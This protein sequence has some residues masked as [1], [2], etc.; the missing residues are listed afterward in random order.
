MR[1]LLAGNHLSAH[2]CSRAPIEDLSD[3]LSGR[4]YTCLR[5]SSFLNGAVRGAHLA[6][7]AVLRYAAYDVAVVDLYSGRAFHWG[8]ML[9]RIFRSLGKPFVV[10]L[11]GGDLPSYATARPDAVRRCLARAS[12]VV[13]PS[14]YLIDSM[15]RYRSDIRY[16]PN[17][18]D[19]EQLPYRHRES[20]APRLV[21]V[22]AFHR[23]Y[24]PVLAPRMMRELLKRFPGATL[25]MLGRDKGD[26]SYQETV[27][28][29]RRLNVGDR[30]VFAGPQPHKE[31][32]KF[33]DA[34]DIFVSTTNFDNTPVS[35]LEAMA[36]GSC[37]VST[38]VG[39]VPWLIENR[40]NGLLVP[41]DHPAAMAEAVAAIVEDCGLAAR[42]SSGAR[43]TALRSDWSQVL[44]KWEALFA[45]IA[46]EGATRTDMAI[47][48]RL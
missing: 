41:P 48:G 27:E 44:P 22:R 21:W 13:A 40:S 31:V 14:G 45:E 17:P 8:D 29:A 47:A 43:A 23:I 7:T 25:T 20:A 46:G 26:G 4:G 39:G 32:G 1:V 30:I 24:N 6:G 15:R 37:V 3:R 18:V 19:I 35:V 33:L 38:A 2:G 11:H 12:A 34:A 9:S 10:A 42:L 5:V 36:C 16:I 28:E